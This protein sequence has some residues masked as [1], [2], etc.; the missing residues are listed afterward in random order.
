[1]TAYTISIVAGRVAVVFCGFTILLPYVLR[2]NRVSQ[3][4]GLGQQNAAPYLQR[5]WPHFWLGY[6]ILAFSIVHAG[7]VMAAMSRANQAGVWAATVALFLLMLEVMLGLFLKEI[8]AS[9][10]IFLRRLHFWNMATVVMLLA[11][12]LWL[13]AT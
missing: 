13:N 7:T 2:R 4:L 5:L 11:A 10:R 12:H 9:G 8:H 1:M 6:L 3:I